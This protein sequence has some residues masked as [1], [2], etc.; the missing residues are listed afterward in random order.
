M[1]DIRTSP[2]VI[3]SEASPSLTFL[4]KL[5][6]TANLPRGWRFGEGVPPT[7]QA[8]DLARSIY[9]KFAFLRLKADVFPVVNGSLLLVFYAGETCVELAISHVGKIDLAVEEGK[10][11]DFQE[12]EGIPNAT[13]A[14]ITRA[15]LFLAEKTER[16]HSSKSFTQKNLTPNSV[17]SAVAA[18]ITPA[19]EQASLWWTVIASNSSQG[20]PEPVPT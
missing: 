15:I 3:F 6:E 10:G 19:T 11:F 8:I 2:Y 14:D 7:K 9:Q 4:I 17:G 13:H 16:W 18:S 12:V 1:T 20:D 5:E